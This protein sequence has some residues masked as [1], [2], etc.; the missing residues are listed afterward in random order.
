MIECKNCKNIVK[1]GNL[2]GCKNC[3]A[4]ICASCGEKTKKICPYCYS[5]LEFF[6]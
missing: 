5:D 3:G 4:Y 2:L 6:G 1:D